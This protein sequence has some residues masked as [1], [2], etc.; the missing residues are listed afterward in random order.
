MVCAGLGEF[1]S[2]F[3][4]SESFDC[5]LT[6]VGRTGLDESVSAYSW[7]TLGRLWANSRNSER[8]QN[9]AG[10]AVVAFVIECLERFFTEPLTE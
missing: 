4:L 8:L 2:S 7:Q 6:K 10:I 9:F 5:N 1:F 3:P